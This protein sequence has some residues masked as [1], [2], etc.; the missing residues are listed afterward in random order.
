MDEI[1]FS[2]DVKKIIVHQVASAL[3][4]LHTR[5]PKIAHCDV[6][7]ENIL[8][9]KYKNAKLADFGLSA[10][11]NAAQ[12]SCNN[13][14]APP[15]QGTLRYSAPEVLRGELLSMSRLLMSDIYSLAIVVFELLMEEE[16]YEGLSLLQL[17][18]HVG[19]GRMQPP[20]DSII[21]TR[22]V[23]DI[24]ERSW[25]VSASQRPTALEFM[26]EWSQLLT[27]FKGGGTCQN[28]KIFFLHK[29]YL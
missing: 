27:L 10:V 13:A 28:S 9:D 11:K 16:P 2:S 14:R 18:E 23:I 25:D 5:D 22:P 15:G 7:S 24:L 3:N 12:T 19:R 21:L 29:C 20:L 1:E 4:Y 26:T 6:K 17:Q 8:L